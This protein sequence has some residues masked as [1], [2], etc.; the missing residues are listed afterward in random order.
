M[1]CIGDDSGLE[2][3]SLNNEPGVYSA[4][5]NGTRDMELNVQLVLDKLKNHTN[6]KARFRT[7]LSLMLKGKEYFFEGTINGHITE[8][9]S[10][11]EGFGYDPIFIPAGYYQTF[12]EMTFEQKNM[13]S[14]RSIALKKM[15]RFL[16]LST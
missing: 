11:D 4:R 1:N 15:L 13:I 10:G 8:K 6:R 2:V 3:E 7:V 12:A 14:H 5:Y 9:R 16:K